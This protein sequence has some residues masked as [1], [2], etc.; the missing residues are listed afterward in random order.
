M[1][2]DTFEFIESYCT[3][4]DMIINGE[5][6]LKGTWLATVQVHDDSVWKAIENGEITGLSVGCQATV[7]YLEED[8]E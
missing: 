2:T 6:V 7:E 3:P 8:D 1:Q 5:M 4:A